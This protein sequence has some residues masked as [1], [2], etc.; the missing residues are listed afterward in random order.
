ME[1]RAFAAIWMAVFTGLAATPV[2][3]QKL[4]NG[5]LVLPAA[6]GGAV[7]GWFI[8]SRVIG[9]KSNFTAAILVGIFSAFLAV[10]VAIFSV[11]SVAMALK[12]SIVEG[13]LRLLGAVPVLSL[14]TVYVAWWTIL[15]LGAAIGLS[16]HLVW[17]R[18][19]RKRGVI[20][21]GEMTALSPEGDG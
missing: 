4:E 5:W 6:V 13:P 8:Q 12:P 20:P 19:E 2:I 17:S 1:K 3:L 14:I 21:E 15:P 10:P 16:S 9:Y 11:I 18:I 7:V